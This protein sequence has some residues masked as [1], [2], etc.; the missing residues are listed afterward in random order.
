V[1]LV[2]GIRIFGKRDIGDINLVDVVMVLLLGN[3]V[4]NAITVG[5]GKLAVGLVSAGVLLVADRLI[6]ILYV[7]N[8]WLEMRM[9][10]G[11]TI[12]Y[13]HGKLFR[14]AMQRE[15]VTEED[16][17][18]AARGAGFPDLSKVRLAVLEDNGTISIV[19]VEDE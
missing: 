14:L 7:R 4:Q 5:S 15:G 1:A 16:L 13:D 11:P 18:A 10:G 17:L 12:L 8:P 6:G 3:A 2:V 9:L 19:P